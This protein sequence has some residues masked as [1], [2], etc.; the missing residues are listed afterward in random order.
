MQS[1]VV[2]EEVPKEEAAVKP[3]RALKKQHRGWHLAAELHRM[4]KERAKGNGGCQNKLA[5][6]RRRMTHFAGVAQ[7]KGHCCQGNGRHSVAPR[8]RKRQTFGRRHWTNPE[9]EKG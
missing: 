3:V 6:A 1:G 7:H 2:H 8:T 4:L 9:Y 5:V